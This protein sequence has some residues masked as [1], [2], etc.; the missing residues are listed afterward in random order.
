MNKQAAI[1]K[2]K[3]DM[4]CDILHRELGGKQ[5]AWW[6]RPRGGYFV[7]VNTLDGCASRIVAKAAEA[8]LILTK[9]G[10]A[11]PY[12][13]DPRDRNIRLAPT[14]PGIDELEKAI[15]LLCVC[16]QLVSLEKI[17]GL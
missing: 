11:F 14:Y 10:A 15:E 2:P 16:V 12:G 6:N 8:G 7:S 5:I 9:A 13:K 17:M 4:V 3:F 1:L